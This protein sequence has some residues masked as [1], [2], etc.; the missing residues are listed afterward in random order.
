MLIVR[1]EKGQDYL[2]TWQGGVRG[3]QKI[4]MVTKVWRLQEGYKG[5][6]TEPWGCGLDLLSGGHQVNVSVS[7]FWGSLWSGDFE[8]LELK[9]FF[10]CFFCFWFLFVVVVVV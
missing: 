3:W 10:F 1:A 2:T 4:T 8:V 7:S 6:E 5:A 9:G